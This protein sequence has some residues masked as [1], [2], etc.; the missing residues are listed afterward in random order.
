MRNLT[1]ESRLKSREIQFQNLINAGYKRETYKG[2]DFFTIENGKYFT[3]KVFKGTGANFLEYV[4][5]HTAE[6]RQS[7][8]NNYKSNYDRNEQ[9]KAEQKAKGYTSSHAGAA[10]AIKAELKAAFPGVKF[11]VNSESFSM[12]NS[13]NIN[14]T[15]GP[16]VAEVEK[17]SSKYQYGHFNGMEDLYE[18]T[19]ERNDIPQV[20]Y[21][22]ESRN[23][24]EAIANLLP[25]LTAFFTPQMSENWH[26]SPENILYRIFA[27]TSFP[28][29][30]SNPKIVRTDKTC[31]QLEDFYK[32]VF[33]SD[34]APDP[35]KKE[36]ETPQYKEVET[37]PGEVNIVD[38]SEKAF[39]VIGDTK[40]IKDT[41]KALGGSFNP[42]LSC[43]AGWIFSKKKLAEVTAALTQDT[44]PQQQPENTEIEPE[45]QPDETPQNYST[46]QDIREA[47]NTG[48]VISLYNLYELVNN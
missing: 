23:K 25:E 31:G 46:L 12:G 36:S 38:Y 4:N 37:M 19:N 18:Y 17:I 3:L 22:T 21:V 26:N 35:T 14:W 42:R 10:A 2:L 16:T 24:S 6:R 44:E 20:K 11:S 29:S 28:A 48:K 13:V 27:K 39:A 40:P 45:A 41:L 30:Y 15:D 1:K 9:Y 5:Y 34:A 8:I 32:I 7:I 43:G 33:E 47:A